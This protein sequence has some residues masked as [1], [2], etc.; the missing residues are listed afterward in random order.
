MKK[1]KPPHEW[2]FWTNL[3]ESSEQKIKEEKWDLGIF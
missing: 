1:R 2:L 3:K